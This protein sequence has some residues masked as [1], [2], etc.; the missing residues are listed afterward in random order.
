MA[1][2]PFKAM[3]AANRE[4]SKVLRKDTRTDFKVTQKGLDAIASNLLT[5]QGSLGKKLTK[6]NAKT[7]DA[8]RRVQAT[9]K[10]R[11]NGLVSGGQKTVANRYGTAIAANPELFR[12]TK[13]VAKGSKQQAKADIGATS[14]LNRAGSEA[15]T[16]IRAAGQ[17]A[18]SAADYEL[19][20]ALRE[21]T[22]ADA[23][24]IMAAR[25]EVRMAKLDAE[26]NERYLRL[27]TRLAN[28]GAGGEGFQAAAD[29]VMALNTEGAS[30]EEL[31]ANVNALAVQHNLGP[32]QKAKLLEMVSSLSSGEAAANGSEAA[33]AYTEEQGMSPSAY[34]DQTEEA[35]LNAATWR[36]FDPSKEVPDTAEALRILGVSFNSEG[37]PVNGNEEE[38]APEFVQAGIAY[39]Q[40]TW[41]RIQA[42]V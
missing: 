26:L 1:K 42:K 27:Q 15:L 33:Q 21:R 36:A 5:T 39:V 30:P 31:R 3:K 37:K 14:M 40:S 23:E 11:V 12:G 29:V 32:A 34:L 4:T 10:E 7:L 6:Q 19:A 8:M 24:A 9:N 25:Q 16:T 18:A 20:A 38:L 22:T 28:G 17:T 35:Q 41:Q 13:T 2:N